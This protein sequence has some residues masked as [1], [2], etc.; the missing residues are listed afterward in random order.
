MVDIDLPK[1]PNEIGTIRRMFLDPTASH[2]II[3]TTLGENYYLHTQSRTPRPLSRLK[4]IKIECVSWN[5]SQPTASTREILLGASDG[6][7]FEIFL[8]L[9]TEFYRRDE[10]YVQNI[11]RTEAPVCSIWTDLV[12]GR[13]EMRRVVLVTPGRLLH[14]IGKIGRTGAEGS[15][16]IFAK[17][18]ETEEPVIHEPDPGPNPPMFS[19]FAVTPEAGD[20]PGLESSRPDRIFAWLSS[21]TV[22]HGQL[23][24]SPTTREL[25]KRVFGETRKMRDSVLAASEGGARQSRHLALTQWHVLQLFGDR[26]VAS[27]RL[28]DSVVYDRSILS[29]GE[30]PLTLM[31]DPKKN[32]FWLFSTKSIY[33]VV[34]RDED[35]DIWRIMVKLQR[36]EEALQYANNSAQ[37]DAVALASGDFLVQ[38]EQYMEAAGVYGKSSKP[39]EEVSLIFIDKNQK[40]ALRKYLLTRLTTLGKSATMQRIMLTSWI[41]ELFMSKLNMLEDMVTTGAE[42]EHTKSAADVENQLG[43][44]RRDFQDFVRRWRDDLDRRTVYDIMNS[45]GREKELLFFSSAIN[46]YNYVLSYWIQRENWTEALKA[47]NRQSSADILY[48]YSS[49]LMAH[50]PVAFVDVLMRFADLEPRRLIPACLNY[51]QTHPDIAL[52]ENQAIRYLNFEITQHGSTDAAVHNTLLS[53]Y[54]SHPSTDEGPLLAY[55]ESQSPSTLSAER[56]RNQK[57]PFD[58]DFALRLCIQHARVR[59]C[60]FLYS[61]MSQYA[62]AVTLALQHGQTDVAVS[63]AERLEHNAATRKRLW[64]AIARSVIAGETPGDLAN[65]TSVDKAKEARQP[66][67]LEPKQKPGDDAR[68]QAA[69]ISTALALL[70]RAPPEVLRIEDLLPLFP[71]FVLIDG[72]KEEICGALAGYSAQIDSL[73]AEMDASS[74]TASRL[75][76]DTASLRRRWVLV[77]PGEG[78]AV[79]GEALLERRFWVWH[80]GHGIHGDCVVRELSRKAGKGAAR[81]VREIRGQLEAGSAGKAAAAPAP[82]SS[83]ASVAGSG[84]AVEGARRQQLVAELDEL[85]GAECTLCGS[86]AVRAVDLPFVE[87]QADGAAPDPWAL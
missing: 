5:P 18:F 71:D 17:F 81:R 79:C 73:R 68:R 25:G 31:A 46:D 30:T 83:V 22:M 69:S 35:R 52:R 48:K 60:V 77:E 86:L 84:T 11:Y 40:D 72:L 13:S 57:V 75:S 80:C 8:E 2:L 67:G 59:S 43:L 29:E 44:T 19:H 87:P 70:K 32:T 16:S 37:K 21:Q 74:A 55:L 34:A 54:A 85:L 4:G 28:D 6:R 26:V 24:L 64:L 20:A 14:F 9:S 12:P 47:L 65:A 49:A 10:R 3:S 27:N 38:K 82:A 33:E 42:L 15:G 7:I 76:R 41:V 45:H 58:S 51:N 23:S 1:K 36:F 63:V 56:M 66:K 53:M 62:S 50:A 61:L 39:F 78:C